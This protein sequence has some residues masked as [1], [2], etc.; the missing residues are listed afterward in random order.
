MKYLKDNRGVLPVV[1]AIL[2]V[3]LVAVVGVALYN[4]SKA[5]QNTTTAARP[6]PSPS[7]SP[8]ATSSPSVLPAVQPDNDQVVQAVRGYDSQSANDTITG[9]TIVGL[10]AKGNGTSPGA[11]SGYRF[12]A[13]KSSGSWKVI[14]RGQEQ[15]GKALGEQYGLPAGWYSTAY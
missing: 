12:I 4:V 11:P 2:V 14:Y 1:V 7:K 15:P 9:I 13:H 3:L 5:H 6:S 8:T 10:N